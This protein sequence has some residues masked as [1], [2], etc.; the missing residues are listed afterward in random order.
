MVKFDLG[1]YTPEI[2]HAF[3]EEISKNSGP[4]LSPEIQKE[5]IDLTGDPL[6]Y[7][8][9]L[10][11]NKLS[12]LVRNRPMGIPIHSEDLAQAF[13]QAANES[14]LSTWLERLSDQLSPEDA[15][16][17]KAL[18]DTLSRKAT[19][20]KRFQLEQILAKHNVAIEQINDK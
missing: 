2:A 11:F 17:A 9:Q 19:A 3:L 15:R 1:A 18:L 13:E 4:V 16:L 5:L 10:L 8:L 12:S 6:P 20:L 7:Y 14:N